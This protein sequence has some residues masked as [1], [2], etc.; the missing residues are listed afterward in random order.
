MDYGSG[1]YF[2]EFCIEDNQILNIDY[3]KVVEGYG[4]KIY[5][6]NMVEELKVV[7]EDVKMQDV[8]MLIEMKVLLKMMIDGYDSWWYVGVVE[9]FEQESV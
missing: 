8:F 1:S 3:V 2:C 6:V 5:R 9:V 7:F 4:V